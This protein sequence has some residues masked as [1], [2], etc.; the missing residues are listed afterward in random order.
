MKILDAKFFEKVARR[1]P[2]HVFNNHLK[3]KKKKEFCNLTSNDLEM[4]EIAVMYSLKLPSLFQRVS[5]HKF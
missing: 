4:P 5:A 3:K 2:F 1:N